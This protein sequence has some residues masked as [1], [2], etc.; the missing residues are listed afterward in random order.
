LGE[1]LNPRK[2]LNFDVYVTNEGT[3]MLAGPGNKV[4][5]IIGKFDNGP[6]MDVQNVENTPGK[7]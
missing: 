1:G 2:R 5:D 4:S 3:L 6:T 7:V